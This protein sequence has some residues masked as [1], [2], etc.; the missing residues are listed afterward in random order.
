MEVYLLAD[1][2]VLPAFK[3][4]V[5]GKFWTFVT[6]TAY[7]VHFICLLTRI[8]PHVSDTDAV[9]WAFARE[10]LKEAAEIAGNRKPQTERWIVGNR[11]IRQ[12]GLLAEE[13]FRAFTGVPL[14]EV[15]ESAW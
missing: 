4:C 9:F 14:D 11:L 2:Y 13:I 10:S 7:P 5:L 8:A 12:G 6:I 3:T 1:K 15:E